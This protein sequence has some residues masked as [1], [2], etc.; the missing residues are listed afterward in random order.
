MD[1]RYD[2]FVRYEDAGLGAEEFEKTRRFTRPTERAPVSSAKN[3][4]EAFDTN[5]QEEN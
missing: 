2:R 1:D 4:T 5:S 3:T